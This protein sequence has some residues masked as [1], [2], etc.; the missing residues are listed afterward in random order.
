MGHFVSS[1]RIKRDVTNTTFGNNIQSC[2]EN[3]NVSTNLENWNELFGCYV[4]W[5]SNYNF[6]FP[7]GFELCNANNDTSILMDIWYN[8][9]QILFDT[10][11]NWTQYSLENVTEITKYENDTNND[12]LCRLWQLASIWDFSTKWNFAFWKKFCHD[13]M[14]VEMIPLQVI[15]ALIIL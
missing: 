2:I 9:T 1:Q 12:D 5:E 14:D 10:W 8:D 7:E 4:E 15:Q 3:K 13:A 11:F 6:T